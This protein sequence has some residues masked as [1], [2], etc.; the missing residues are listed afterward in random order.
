MHELLELAQ[1]TRQR[2]LMAADDLSRLT[3][4][5]RRQVRAIG[6]ARAA[7]C[8]DQDVQHD[9]HDTQTEPEKEAP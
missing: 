9:Q 6:D 1:T 2:L 4:E 7:D 5:L 3:K 8:D